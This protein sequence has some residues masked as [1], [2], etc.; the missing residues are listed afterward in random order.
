MNSS[1]WPAG[2]P[3]DLERALDSMVERIIDQ[4]RRRKRIGEVLSGLGKV[5]LAG[6]EDLVEKSLVRE[7]KRDPLSDL[8]VCGVDGGLLDQQLH[9][10]D[11]ILIRAVAVIFHYR[12]ALLN[13]AEYLPSEFPPLRMVDVAEPLDAWEF[14]LL[15]GMER[16]LAELEVATEAAERDGIGAI[17]LDGSIVPQYVERFPRSPV[18]VERYQKLIQA[19][20]K[21][22]QTCARSGVLLCGAVKD[23]RGARFVE[24]LKR[25]LRDKFGLSLEKE[26]FSVLNRSRDTV[27]LNH[28]L[29]VG[30][31]TSAFTYAEK[32]ASY[33]LSDLGPWAPKIC[34]FYIKTVPFDRPLRVE[35]LDQGEDTAA[36]ADR[37]ASLIFALSSHHDGFGLPS[38]IVEADA[39][40]RLAEEDLC[41]VRDSISDRLE[42]SLFLELRRE[43][44][45]F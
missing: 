16:Q 33:V 8:K 25:E 38:V 30:Q 18:L 4:E 31:R 12:R 44:K 23:S 26:D 37:V 36:T 14:Q 5:S 10:L 22:Y 6:V 28:L 29:Q 3:G 35:F 9:G 19:Y 39:C 13:G 1:A 40:V 34:A 24:I 11:L 42:P 17:L 41:L 45:P 7:V 15:A 32:P 27:L 21:L 20:T 43:K 2:F